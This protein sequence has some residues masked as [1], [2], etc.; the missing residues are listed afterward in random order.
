MHYLDHL[1]E[2]GNP[3]SEE[4]K[5]TTRTLGQRVWIQSSDFE[6]SLNDAFHLWDSVSNFQC[7]FQCDDSVEN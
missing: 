6:G 4:T 3:T 5:S 1:C 7:N 2:K